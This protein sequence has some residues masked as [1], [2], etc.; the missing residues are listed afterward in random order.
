MKVIFCKHCNYFVSKATYYWHL[1]LT[2]SNQL[3][4]DHDL[5]EETDSSDMSY[6]IHDCMTVEDNTCVANFNMKGVMKG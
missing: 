1:K 5:D 4:S 6:N 3:R 2:K